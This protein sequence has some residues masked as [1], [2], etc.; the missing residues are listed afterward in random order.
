MTEPHGKKGK[1]IQSRLLLLIVFIL[2]PVLALQAYTYYANYQ[3]LRAIELESNLELARAV[4][5]A[6]DSFIQNVLNQELAIGLAITSSQQ[7]SAKDISRL[8]KSSRGNPAVR[9]FTWMNPKGDAIHSSNDAM[10]GRNYS[11]RS[12]FR[13]VTNGHEWSVS[14]LI[15]AKTT[16]EPT[17][18]I[19]RGIRD[20][21][22]ALLGIVFA[23]IIPEK[24]NTILSFERGKNAGV[25]LIDNKGIHVARWPKTEYTWEQRNWL[26]HYPVIA[27]ALAGKETTSIVTSESS[28]TKRIV[29]F[30]LVSKIGWVA[31]ASR[32]EQDVVA[33]IL[34]AMLPQ[35][36]LFLIT[37]FLGILAAL[38]LSHPIVVS[39]RRLRDHALM[40][41]RGDMKTIEI[42]SGPSEIKDLSESFNQM[43]QE[44]QN[45]DAALRASEARLRRFYE[46]GLVGVIYWN[47]DG[48]ITDANDKFLEMIGHSRE[49]LEARRI[50]WVSLTPPEYRHLDE[51]SVAELKTTG[52]NEHP[53]EKEYIR[54]DGSRFPIIVAGAM[55]DEKRFDGVALVLD[56]TQR[57]RAEEALKEANESL[58]QKVGERTMDL[59]HLT[60]QLERSRV[61]LR[62]LASEL[63]MAEE[64]ERK[65]IAGVLHDDIA[66]VLAAVR[67]RLDLFRD[68]PADQKDNTLQEAK[69][70]L[71]ESIQETRGLMNDLGNPLLF[72]LGLR[73]ACEAL[74]NRMM[75]RSPTRIS[76][77]IRE[78][79]K[80]L[81]PDMKMILYQIVREL[82]NNIIKHSKAQNAHVLIDSENEHYRVQ[83]RDDGVGFEPQ[84]LGAPTA[85]GGFGLYSMRERLIAVDGN[86]VIESSPGAGTVVTAILPTALD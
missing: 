22:G 52:V 58:E 40:L 16:G 3:S 7:M 70:L 80:N 61:E 47:M 26:K 20:S 32:A 86:L 83:V 56:I 24:L 49:D 14:E 10:I 79:Y 74:A 17:F 9:D 55:L 64:R 42:T 82:L 62:K 78:P 36:I 34:S 46:S 53:F 66:Q 54:K 2:I 67:M 59:Q 65:R 8:L 85:E 57:K 60:A 27:E 21:K 23:A 75:E 43:A 13:E 76:C 29:A 35:G 6:F 5:T 31:S 12:Y 45:R 30:T 38:A 77:D 72:D 15:L 4:S 39:L 11:D 1:S 73:S 25:S 48:V 69:E 18:G 41:G 28:G 63:V 44:I 71:L 51:Q 84:A 50:D 33:T 81:D 37:L 19:S 68:V